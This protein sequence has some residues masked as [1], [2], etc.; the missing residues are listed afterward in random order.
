M[1]SAFV[2]GRSLG[3]DNVSRTYL[4]LCDYTED[5]LSLDSKRNGIR[6]LWAGLLVRRADAND[7]KIEMCQEKKEPSGTGSQ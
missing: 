2:Q 4:T 6:L 1:K 3:A 7:E 5:V